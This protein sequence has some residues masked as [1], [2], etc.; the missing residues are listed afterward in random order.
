MPCFRVNKA[1][2]KL[3]ERNLNMRRLGISIY[4]EKSDKQTILKI[5]DAFEGQ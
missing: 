3:K 1:F 2:S 5:F 4:P